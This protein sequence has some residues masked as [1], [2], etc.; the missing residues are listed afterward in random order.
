MKVSIW[1]IAFEQIKPQI[2]IHSKREGKSPSK[3]KTKPKQD[4]TK[5]MNKQTKRSQTQK[6]PKNSKKAKGF[7]IIF[8]L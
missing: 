2:K 8:K 5:Q 1:W 6:S 4:K 3:Q 7:L